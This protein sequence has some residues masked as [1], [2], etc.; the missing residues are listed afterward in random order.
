MAS[1]DITTITQGGQSLTV[2]APRSTWRELLAWFDEADFTG[3]SPP[4]SWV[5]DSSRPDRWVLPSGRVFDVPEDGWND[6]EVEEA[7]LRAQITPEMQAQLK[8]EQRRAIDQLV[9]DIKKFERKEQATRAG[10]TGL[11]AY[12]PG[13][14]LDQPEIQERIATFVA[15][16]GVAPDLLL[17]AVAEAAAV[18]RSSSDFGLSVMHE[19]ACLAV[20]DFKDKAEPATPFF[21]NDEFS[22]IAEYIHKSVLITAASDREFFIDDQPVPVSLINALI[23]NFL[24]RC[25]LW[26]QV[27]N[28][29]AAINNRFVAEV[30]GAL[31]RKFPR[32]PRFVAEGARAA[33]IVRATLTLPSASQ[34][35]SSPAV[36]CEELFVLLPERFT[37]S[38]TL[39]NSYVAFCSRCGA[40][41]VARG[42]FF[43]ALGQWARGR[44]RAT[45]RGTPRL[46]GYLGVAPR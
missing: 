14:S 27:R 42:A 17:I 23:Q 6:A 40:A 44:V 20:Q 46:P 31:A 10:K 45:K 7:L 9:E 29:P 1:K 38:E 36:A 35:G 21:H 28:I 4:A 39:W 12:C 11:Q 8:P 30:R 33:G 37:P 26:D 15:F 34:A 41:P 19:F 18:M 16:D 22:R 5:V 24:E 3:L 43:K 32:A 13:A 2:H 25:R